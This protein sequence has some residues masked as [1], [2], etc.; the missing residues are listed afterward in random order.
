MENNH[1]KA[2]YCIITKEDDDYSFDHKMVTYDWRSAVGCAQRNNNE[3][4]ATWLKFG[5]LQK[6]INLQ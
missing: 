3:E 1:N 6:A 5:Q 2:R 4:W